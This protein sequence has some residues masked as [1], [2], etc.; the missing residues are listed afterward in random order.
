VLFRLYAYTVLRTTHLNALTHI[1]FCS[2]DGNAETN[3]ND[4]GAG[5]M[6]CIYFGTCKI[7]GYGNGTGPW[8]ECVIIASAPEARMNSHGAT[9]PD[10]AAAACA[11]G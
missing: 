6:E 9:W 8:Y 7:W 10:S 3:N 1:S 11:A 2:A 4:D 5:T